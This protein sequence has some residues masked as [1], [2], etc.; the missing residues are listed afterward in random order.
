MPQWNICD[1]YSHGLC[2]KYGGMTVSKE[3]YFLG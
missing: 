1:S 3:L 2:N